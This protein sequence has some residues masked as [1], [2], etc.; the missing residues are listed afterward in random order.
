MGMGAKGREGKQVAKEGA[1]WLLRTGKGCAK[2]QVWSGFREACGNPC[3]TTNAA[4]WMSVN[5]SVGCL[6]VENRGWERWE[7]CL[8]D[9]VMRAISMLISIGRGGMGQA[10]VFEEPIGLPT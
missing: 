3:V 4:N 8:A 1:A 9:N 7:D 5:Q 10:S 2:G 6:I